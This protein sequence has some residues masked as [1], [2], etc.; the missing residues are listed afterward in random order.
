M[1]ERTEEE[2]LVELAARTRQL[3]REIN[4][5]D[6]AWTAIA[7][8][9]KMPLAKAEPWIGGPRPRL[10]QRPV[11]LAAAAVALVAVSSLVT[12]IALGKREQPETSPIVVAPTQV[13]RNSRSGPATLTEFASIERNY[14]STAIS[15]AEV[16][17]D[18]KTTF[19]PQTVVKLRESIRVIDAAIVEARRALAA[20]PANR[21]LIEM[22]TTSYNQKL[23]LLRRTTEMGRS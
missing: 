19:S 16:L 14:I 7:G 13:N 1:T 4:P 23:D 3:P 20:D 17:E 5:P 21:A 2:L 22:L 10:W 18:G 9:I 12:T 11:F 8:K 15:L 6:D